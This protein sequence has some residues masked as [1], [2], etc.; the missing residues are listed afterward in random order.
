M[1]FLYVSP[2]IIYIPAGI[3]LFCFF[4]RFLTLFPFG[5]KKIPST[6]LS[7]LFAVFCAALGWRVYGLGAVIV[8]HFVLILVLCEGVNWILK[9]VAA[10]ER[11]KRIW[12]IVFKSGLVSIVATA[13][14]FCY[15]YINIQDVRETVYSVRSQ[16]NLVEPLRIVQISDLHMGTTMDVEALNEYC[17]RIGER[18]PDLVVL[19]GDIFDES[20]EK[21]VMTEA[22]SALAGISAKYGVYYVWGNHDPN[23]YRKQPNYSM[24]E[25]RQTL[26]NSGIRVLEDEAVQVAPQLTV[27]GR[28]DVSNVSGRKSVRELLQGVDAAS[29]IVL[30]DHRPVE[31]EENASAGV[32]LQLSGHTHAGQIWPTGQLSE[33][34]GINEKNYGMATIGDFHAIVSS[35]IAGWG[36]AIRT[37]GH[38]E[39]VIVDVRGRTL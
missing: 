39:Y 7:A 38:S 3:Y 33:L 36:Y 37:G 4:K 26:L 10:S 20:T 12:E 29:Y 6:A 27:V 9:R 11:F 15:G 2:L 35:G 24:D 23:R 22:V 28:Y 1:G 13:V 5:N 18:E 30:L 16:K 32:D 31:L 17:G 19:T 8:L 34:L 25:L 14:V 21:P